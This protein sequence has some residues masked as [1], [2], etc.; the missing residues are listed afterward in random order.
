MATG[1]KSGGRKRGTPNKKAKQLVELIQKHFKGFDPL[2][3][4]VNIYMDGNTPLDMRFQILKEM[5]TY[6]HPKRKSV[7]AD[8]ITNTEQDNRDIE[9][10]IEA[11]RRGEE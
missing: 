7:D 9:D 1:F 5:A 6:F 8:A 4:M 2:L 11:I 10:I 3:Q